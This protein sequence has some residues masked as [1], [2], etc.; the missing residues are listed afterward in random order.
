MKAN[1]AF[2]A[3][4]TRRNAA[5]KELLELRPPAIGWSQPS[6]G[7][8]LFTITLRH[9]YEDKEGDICRQTLSIHMT[10]TELADLIAR[11]G[12]MLNDHPE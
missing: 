9:E 4:M 3:P 10:R 11:L 1:R 12:L 8:A 6:G 2:C 5:A 7:Q